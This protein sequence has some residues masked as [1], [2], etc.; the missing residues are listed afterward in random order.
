[1]TNAEL[2]EIRKKWKSLLRQTVLKLEDV[3]PNW[4]SI[5]LDVESLRPFLSEPNEQGKDPADGVAELFWN[6]F[7]P[8]RRTIDYPTFNMPEAVAE[9]LS[10]EHER[11]IL[12]LL[13]H[14]QMQ[15]EVPLREP[16]D[17]DSQWIEELQIY[18][19][20][21]AARA[22]RIMRYE[23]GYSEAARE[24]LEDAEEAIERIR[25]A[26]R[27]LGG[28]DIGVLG[29]TLVDLSTNAVSALV[30]AERCRIQRGADELEEALHYVARA[31]LLFYLASGNSSDAV[32]NE[33]TSQSNQFCHA[34]E[35]F[36]LYNAIEDNQTRCPGLAAGH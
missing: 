36:G 9:P 4:G 13:H 23:S 14:L 26:K 1:M 28:Y 31:D 3:N 18:L 30:L 20:I 32:S 10:S 7:Q 2:H 5:R 29:T 15:N 17:D 24:C 19:H 8:L 34:S 33:R 11:L 27:A 21:V 16:D 22:F 12:D 25:F 35:A 6:Q